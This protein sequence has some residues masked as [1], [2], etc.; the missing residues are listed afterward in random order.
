ML[1]KA[2]NKVK[3]THSS[4]FKKCLQLFCSLS[5]ILSRLSSRGGGNMRDKEADWSMPATLLQESTV[6][7]K[8]G[9]EH[10]LIIVTQ[11]DF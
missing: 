1:T 11:A 6:Y 9:Q 2:E 3:V 4:C 10:N 5:T 7:G 8:E